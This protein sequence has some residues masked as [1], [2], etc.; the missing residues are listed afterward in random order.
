MNQNAT[1]E[2]LKLGL[3]EYFTYPKSSELILKIL[4]HSTN[5]GDI[6]LD[7][8]AGSG[9]TGDAVMQFN[10]QDGG[11]R[12]FILVQ[13]PEKID[14]DKNQSTY[15]FIKNTLNVQTDPTIFEITKERLLRSSQ[16]IISSLDEKIATL[17]NELQTEENQA[18]IKKLESCKT[19]SKTQN[20]FKIFETTPIPENYNFEAKLFNNQTLFNVNSLS[21]DDIKALLITWKTYDGIPLTQ[22]LENI[23]LT[24]YTAYYG[25][26]RL[27]LMNKG[28]TTD[29]LKSLLEKIDTDNKFEPKS[30]IAF[31]YNLGSKSLREI[32]ENVKTYNNRK[33]S[34][35][36]FIIRY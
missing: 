7:F 11:N 8:F 1:K 28:F 15:D 2:L 18:E 26:G 10:A 13:L 23:D 27:Y 29:N 16:S 9:T 3:A 25:N 24:G 35:I 20:T 4:Q 32:S 5:K 31:G 14:A 19:Q 12:K 30:I 6:I 17:Q 36:D 21:K 34:D 22:D 33:K